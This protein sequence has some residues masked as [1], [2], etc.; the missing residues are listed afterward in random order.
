[1]D[2][3]TMLGVD[4]IKSVTRGT[5]GASEISLAR[6]AEKGVE[7]ESRLEGKLRVMVSVRN[8]EILLVHFTCHL[9]MTMPVR[10]EKVTGCIFTSMLIFL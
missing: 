3:E 6:C 5:Q 9:N 4:S 2:S 1:M 10:R 8:T 7:K